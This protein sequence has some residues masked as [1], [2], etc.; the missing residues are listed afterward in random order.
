MKNNTIVHELHLGSKLNTSLK[1]SDR[2]DFR[3]LMTLLTEQAQEFAQF[4]LDKESIDQEARDELALKREL[5]IQPTHRLQADNGYYEKVGQISQG[6]HFGGQTSMNLA[7]CMVNDALSQFNDAK[8][9]EDN[10]IDNCSMHTRR[11]LDILASETIKETTKEI[12]K[13]TMSETD[14]F[15]ITQPDISQLGEIA[16]RSRALLF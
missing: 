7:R 13:E 14:D 3:L 2:A 8:K 10:V 12:T 16:E 6:L 9:I 1:Q 5:G 4:Q 15:D 11:R